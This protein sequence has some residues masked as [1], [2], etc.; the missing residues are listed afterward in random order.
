MFLIALLGILHATYFY[1]VP[2]VVR[3]ITAG[4]C[5]A[6][7]IVFVIFQIRQNTRQK[8]SAQGDVDAP[9][10]IRDALANFLLLPAVANLIS[11]GQAD[12]FSI[13]PIACTLEIIPVHLLLRHWSSALAWTA[14]FLSTCSAVWLIGVARAFRLRPS[15]SMHLKNRAESVNVSRKICRP[16]SNRISIPPLPTGSLVAP[17]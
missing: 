3:A 5:E 6:G 10:I 8:L 9:E 16:P 11:V 15:L 7:L 17:A 4:L 2:T 13:L 12:L 14:T 1:P